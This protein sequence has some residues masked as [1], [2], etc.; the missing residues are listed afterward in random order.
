MPQLAAQKKVGLDGR[1]RNKQPFSRLDSAKVIGLD[2]DTAQS[3]Q[4]A[5][6]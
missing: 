4:R 2:H 6:E 3:V 5:L 1:L